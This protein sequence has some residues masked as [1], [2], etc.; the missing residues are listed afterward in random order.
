MQASGSQQTITYATPMTAYQYPQMQQMQ[1]RPQAYYPQQIVQQPYVHQQPMP[2]PGGAVYMHQPQQHVVYQQQPYQQQYQMGSGG[3]TSAHISETDR[4]VDDSKPPV[5]NTGRVHMVISGIDYSCDKQSWA[6]PPP[7]GNG[8]LDTKYA[9]EMMKDLAWK[10]GAQYMTLWNEECTK[11]R[12]CQ[13]IAEVAAKCGPN[14][15][16]IFY[17]TGHG[18]RLPRRDGSQIDGGFDESLCLVDANGNTDD[19]SMQYR[20]QVWLRDDD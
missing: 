10:S 18:D 19:P 7:H 5:P 17:Y 9:F 12:I 16:F 8:P 14:D 20:N 3:H 1:Y 4:R 11:E 2:M 6:G 15:T 13:A